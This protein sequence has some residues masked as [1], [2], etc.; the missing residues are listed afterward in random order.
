MAAETERLRVVVEVAPRE[1]T[2]RLVDSRGNRLEDERFSLA[3]EDDPIDPK[4]AARDVFDLLYQCA[5]TTVN[6]DEW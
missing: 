5:T 2:V 3:P 1:V 6:T 4:T